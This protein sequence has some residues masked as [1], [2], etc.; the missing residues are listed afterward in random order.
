MD[1]RVWYNYERIIP[2]N[3]QIFDTVFKVNP[4]QSNFKFRW[5][6]LYFLCSRSFLVMAVS[7]NSVVQSHQW[8]LYPLTR[9]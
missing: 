3:V 4:S 2:T 6:Q 7:N 8:T 1:P 9:H 5:H